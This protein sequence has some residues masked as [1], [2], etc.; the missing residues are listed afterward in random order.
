MVCESLST[1]YG[2]P[3][4]NGITRDYIYLRLRETDV[5]TKILRSQKQPAARG[6]DVFMDNCQYKTATKEIEATERI[7]NLM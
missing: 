1:V 4:E 5:D 6:G 7:R 2:S 3:E